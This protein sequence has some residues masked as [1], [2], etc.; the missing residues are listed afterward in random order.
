[1]SKIHL[2]VGSQG[3]GKSTTLK[4]LPKKLMEFTCLLTNGCGNYMEPTCQSLWT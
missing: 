2:V 1:M 4:S 3:A